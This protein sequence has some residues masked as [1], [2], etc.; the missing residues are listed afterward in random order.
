M[1]V[2]LTH[3][4]FIDTLLVKNKAFKNK[5]FTVVGIYEGGKVPILLENKYG[6]CKCIPE[7]LIAGFKPNI[8]SAIDKNIYFENMAKEVHGDKYDY[9]LVNYTGYENNVEIVCPIHGT[10]S[11]TPHTHIDNGGCQKCAIIS[12]G[13]K[14]QDLDAFTLS[15]WREL[16]KTSKNFESYKIYVIRL[17]NDEE[18]FIKI[19]R[20]FMKM[21]NRFRRMHYNIEVLKL[22]IFESADDAYNTENEIKR[23]LKVDRYTPINPFGGDKECYNLSILKDTNILSTEDLS[24]LDYIK[25]N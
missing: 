5:E 10:F 13:K 22:F 2:R 15:Q 11:Q 8:T 20:T 23:K 6:V 1:P 21:K 25:N 9:S 12:R 3:E 16:S 24:V 7:N 14:R 18:S 19:G 4:Q 17:F